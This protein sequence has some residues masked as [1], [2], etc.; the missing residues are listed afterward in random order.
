MARTSIQDLQLQGNASNLKRALK[1]PPAQ[2]STKRAELEQ[3]FADLTARRAEALAD[4]RRNGMIINQ[5]RS[6]SRGFVYLVK[7]TNPALKIA[8]QCE[9]QLASLAKQLTET[10]GEDKPPVEKSPMEQL[11]ESLKGK[12]N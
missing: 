6:N 5:D 4:V 3:I 9:R 7:I 10:S 2:R 11:E 8:Q 1:R 12:L